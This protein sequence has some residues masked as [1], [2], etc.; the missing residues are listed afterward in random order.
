M[1]A[2]GF[3]L[4]NNPFDTVTLKLVSGAGSG[5]KDGK[6]TQKKEESVFNISAGGISGVPK[7]IFACF[8]APL[9]V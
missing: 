8:C 6:H 4:E 9:C 1:Y 7:V 3:A 2:Y 5:G